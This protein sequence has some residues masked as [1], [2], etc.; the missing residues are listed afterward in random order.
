MP[1]LM[2]DKVK[3]IQLIGIEN[4]IESVKYPFRKAWAEARWERNGAP[5]TGLGR[6]Q[7]F[8]RTLQTKGAVWP[9]SW[10]TTGSV[11]RT[12]PLDSGVSFLTE[13]GR[14]DLRCLA[15]NVMH[16]RYGSAPITTPETLPYSHALTRPLDA[17]SPPPF[18]IVETDEAIFLLTAM[19]TVGILRETAAVFFADASGRLLHVTLDA[20]G[21]PAGE[22]R[23][24]T[25]LA[26]DEHLFGLGERTTV[27]NRRGRTHVLWNQDPGGYR[28]GDDPININIP[29]Y[30]G[31][32]DNGSYLVFYD[33]PG[34]AEFDLGA[35]VSNVAE[36]RFRDGDLQ[37]VFIAGPVPELLEHYTG[38]TGRHDIPPL[39]ML[40]YHQSR[41]S[42]TPESRVRKLVEDFR[43]HDV[44]CDAIYLDINYM[45]GFRNFTWDRNAF[46]DPPGLI[47]ALAEQ[48]IKLVTIID[49]GVKRD[50]NYAPYRSGLQGRHF[51][52]SPDG[53]VFHAPVW[54][55]L[56]AFPDFTAART[57]AWWGELYRP[58]IE[59]GVAGFW[60]D[61]NEPAAF[62]A[63]GGS[64]LPD[65]VQ[66]HTDHGD[67]SHATLHNIYGMSMVEASRDGIL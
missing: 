38:L 47:A 9:T 28:A 37:F 33:N 10:R 1:T 17:G 39:W 24:R 29:T 64:T 43:K 4:V 42:Y 22:I 46:P 62:S 31:L 26:E 27:W 44:P 59:A 57:R 66:H 61:M 48:G 36:H 25:V 35:G 30:V 19:L 8:V 55:G 11:V 65:I 54:P 50:P 6:L 40:G 20:A 67:A 23:H 5:R 53:S 15:P 51:C 13:A 12:T 49:A 63:T 60:N 58:L 34:Y 56:C 52:T 21:G 7:A 3:A 18:H 45:D 32:H 14:L 41:W 2:H 16:T